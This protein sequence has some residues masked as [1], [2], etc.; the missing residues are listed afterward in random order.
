[1][2][3]AIIHVFVLARFLLVLF[4][5]TAF[6]LA[7]AA[8]THQLSQAPEERAVGAGPPAQRRMALGVPSGQAAI[9]P[10]L[11]PTLRE[12]AS[13]VT[14]AGESCPYMYRCANSDTPTSYKHLQ[15]GL[16]SKFCLVGFLNRGTLAVKKLCGKAGASCKHLESRDGSDP[17]GFVSFATRN[18]RTLFRL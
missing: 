4:W 18:I 6:S 3:I 8:A 16:P 14:A 5:L 7:A 2:P 11:R 15:S 17:E 1:M 13:A 10:R 12:A 9:K